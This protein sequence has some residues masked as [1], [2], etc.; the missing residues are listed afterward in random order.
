MSLLPSAV[1]KEE[2][3]HNMQLLGILIWVVPVLAVA[4]LI[5]FVR[6]FIKRG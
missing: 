3:M 4:A 1:G 5:A 6:I 2:V